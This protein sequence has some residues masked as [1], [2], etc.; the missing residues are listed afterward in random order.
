MDTPIRKVLMTI[1][2]L[3]LLVTGWL[4]MFVVGSDLFAVSPLLPLIAA[5]YGISPALAGLSV[6]VFSGAY[7][8]SAPL[9]GHVADKIGRGRVLAFCLLAF[10]TA[11][12]L[13]AEAGGLTW[14]L[15]AR[16]VAGAAAAGISPSV[17][18]L[19][20][21]GAPYDRRATWLAIVVS[22]LLVALS[23]GAPI[24]GLAAASFGWP[25][26]F[27]GLAVLSL[28]LIWANCRVW[29][30][31]HAA[32]GFAAPLGRLTIAA[33][34]PRLAPTVVW[35]TAL[36]AMYTYL[37]TGLTSKGYSTEEIAAVLVLYGCGAICGV[38]IGGR[39]T[40]W[41]GARSTSA[42]GLA[43][44][45]FC[46][47]LLGLALNAGVGVDLAFGVASAVAQ[48]F[49]PAQQAGLANDFPAR[50]AA[51]LA[52]NNSALF[53]GISL[54]SLIGGQAVS[55]GGFDAD[56]MISAAIA[57]VGWTINWAVTPRPVRSSHQT[58]DQTV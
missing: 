57:V 58:V 53:L 30:D 24:A 25:C 22:G 10:A 52:W 41:L 18:A 34:A 32:E 31:N 8:L 15:A 43:G 17:Y 3:K 37:G 29:L 5:D 26:V 45:C 7:M 21:G 50:R 39:M 48:L 23:L 16:L 56:L 47:V 13:T 36:Y 1:G 46:F 44:L 35:G 51:I 33:I 19:V 6:T 4:T 40:D 9:L 2:A 38:L 55:L 49:F 20:G 11:N 28:L 27:V 14:L 54:G 12:L 42:I